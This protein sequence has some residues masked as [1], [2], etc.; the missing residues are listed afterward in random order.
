MVLDFL[1]ALLNAEVN[2][3]ELL[4]GHHFIMLIHPKFARLIFEDGLE[5]CFIDTFKKRFKYQKDWVTFDFAFL[6]LEF[7]EFLLD[8][9][10]LGLLG[11]QHTMG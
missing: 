2:I 10:E 11:G 1:G 6:V 5:V 9:F 8:Q 3:F 7:A 4:Q